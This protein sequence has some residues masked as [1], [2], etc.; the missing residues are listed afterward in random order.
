M[1]LKVKGCGSDFITV[2]PWCSI[3]REC[4]LLL[5]PSSNI[6]VNEGDQTHSTYKLNLRPPPHVQSPYSCTE[7]K[8]PGL[9][10]IPAPN[11]SRILELE[12]G[13]R[14]LGYPRVHVRLAGP[15]TWVP[16]SPFRGVPG[17]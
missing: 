10:E 5:T 14:V 12:G 15:G 17:S 1:A 4:S 7:K 6:I 13:T 9:A 3:P 8:H 2:N 11:G 16:A